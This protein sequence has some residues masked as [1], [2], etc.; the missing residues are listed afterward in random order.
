M[1]LTVHQIALEQE[2]ARVALDV[3]RREAGLERERIGRE[4]QDLTVIINQKKREIEALENQRQRLAGEIT[5]KIEEG[6]EGRI[7]L[8]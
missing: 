1:D 5:Q 6:N 3:F 7:W 8:T 4:F 2:Q